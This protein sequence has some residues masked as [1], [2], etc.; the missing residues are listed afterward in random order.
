MTQQLAIKSPRFS[1]LCSVLC[2]Q[3]SLIGGIYVQLIFIFNNYIFICIFLIQSNNN[4]ISGLEK[5][6]Q[7][8][9]DN[10]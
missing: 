2:T 6:P 7:A 3:Q 4:A 9:L 1:L 8:C 10:Q 5:W